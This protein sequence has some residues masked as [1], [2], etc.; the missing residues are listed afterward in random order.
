[1]IKTSH[2]ANLK[3]LIIAKAKTILRGIDD[4]EYLN[5]EFE[6]EFQA[7]W[8]IKYCSK[9]KPQEI[10]LCLVDFQNLQNHRGIF[11]QARTQF[12]QADFLQ[13][14]PARYVFGLH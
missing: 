9:D 10:G 11:G 3:G 12:C 6:R 5:K 2:S 7:Y 8:N 1:M 13:L 4:E 14:L